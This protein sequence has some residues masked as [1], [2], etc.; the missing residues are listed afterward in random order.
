[1]EVGP[2]A[3][4]RRLIRSA[5][6]EHTRRTPRAIV[7]QRQA[8]VA[9]AAAQD[10]RPDMHLPVAS[11]WRRW[12]GAIWANAKPPLPPSTPRM[13]GRIC[14]CRSRSRRCRRRRPGCAAGHASAGR[15]ALAQVA[16]S[17]QGQ[18]GRCMERRRADRIGRAAL[19][20]GRRPG[21]IN[22]YA[23]PWPSPWAGA[24]IHPMEPGH[25]RRPVSRSNPVIH[26]GAGHP[27]SPPRHL[28][29]D[30]L[31]WW[32]ADSDRLQPQR[33]VSPGSAGRVAAA[34]ERRRP[35]LTHRALPSHQ[36]QA[37]SGRSHR[38]S[39]PTGEGLLSLLRLQD[40]HRGRHAVLHI[41]VPPEAVA[42]LD[43]LGASA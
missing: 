20:L 32:R 2:R 29:Q 22:G 26:N 23:G 19:A 38:P 4:A 25:G 33:I 16:G 42:V 31:A 1:M 6:V 13:C 30:H 9:A 43:A 3:G 17:D 12:L 24:P 37:R 40:P 7:G 35:P 27:P 5:R 10:V 28:G 36:R 8:A 21:S 18:R 14:S 15:S 39:G 41:S 11:R 34:S